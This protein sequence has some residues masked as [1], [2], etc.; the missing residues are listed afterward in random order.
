M[1]GR[2]VGHEPGQQSAQHRC[3]YWNLHTVYETRPRAASSAGAEALEP[4]LDLDELVEP[5]RIQRGAGATSTSVP[6]G[7]WTR[8]GD[9]ARHMYA[10][11][12]SVLS[13]TSLPFRAKEPMRDMNAKSKRKHARIRD[14]KP[15][16]YPEKGVFMRCMSEMYDEMS[17]SEYADALGTVS[18]L[19]QRFVVPGVSQLTRF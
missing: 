12:D 11:M 1:D 10:L 14:R 4:K 19:L 8:S 5:L 17:K 6:T 18:E 9:A 16:R 3:N 7:G 2:E 15:S 13:S